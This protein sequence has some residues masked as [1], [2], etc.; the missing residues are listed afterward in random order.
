MQLATRDM[1]VLTH[2]QVSAF[3]RRENLTHVTKY[4]P[5]D[6]LGLYTSY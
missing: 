3:N 1:V 2:A 4:G 6:H 5:V